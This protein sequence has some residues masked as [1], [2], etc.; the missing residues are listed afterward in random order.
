MQ[1]K[2]IVANIAT[3][4]VGKAKAFYGEI[5]GLDLAMDLGWI[6][7]FASKAAMKPEVSVASEGGGLERRSLTCSSG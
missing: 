1:V 7:T 5:L 6:A 4:D 3:T 2:R